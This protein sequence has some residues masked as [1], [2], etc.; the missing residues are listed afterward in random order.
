MKCPHASP[1]ATGCAR[2]QTQRKIDDAT[3]ALRTQNA[4]LRE[5]LEIVATCPPEAL[6]LMPLAAQAM[7]RE[8]PPIGTEK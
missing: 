7:L 6:H 8:V 4:K 2:C 1:S 3:A 5:A